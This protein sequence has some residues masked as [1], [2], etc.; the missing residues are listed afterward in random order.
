[1]IGRIALDQQHANAARIKKGDALVRP[2]RQ[3]LAAHDLGIELYATIDIAH[4]NAEMCDAFD[5]WHRLSLLAFSPDARD[6]V[7]YLACY[8]ILILCAPGAETQ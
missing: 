6:M 3:V 1:M 4:R 2:L 7:S 8:A 5:V